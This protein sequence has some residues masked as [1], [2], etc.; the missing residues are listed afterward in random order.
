MLAP[1]AKWINRLFRRKRPAL[2]RWFAG[3]RRGGSADEGDGHRGGQA[4]FREYAKT[5]QSPDTLRRWESA[6]SHRL[7]SGH[8]SGANGDTINNDLAFWLGTLRA[9]CAHE[10]ANNPTLEGVLNTHCTD[11]IGPR[12][13]KLQVQSSKKTYNEKL[14]RIWRD[15]FK[16]PEITGKL[17]GAAMMQLWWRGL[18]G[19][20][21]YLAQIVT[22]KT[23]DGPVKMRLKLVPVRRLATPIAS[24]A[25]ASIVLGVERDANGKPVAYHIAPAADSLGGWTGKS[26]RIEAKHII[27]EFCT[28]EEEQV[29]GVPWLAV[30]LK[31]IADTRDYDDQVLDAAR[32]AA[33]YSVMMEATGPDVEF[34]AVN[35]EIDI[36]PGVIRH[37]VPGWKANGLTPPQPSTQYKDYHDEL[38]RNFGRAV[39]MPLMMIKLDSAKHNY[40]SARF[41]AQV[42][43]RANDVKKAWIADG[44]M[45]R[46][47]DLVAREAE[48]TGLLPKRPPHV[49]YKWTWHA[50]ASVD[51]IKD[52][53]AEQQRLANGTTTLRDEC[54][55]RGFDWEEVI[56]QRAREMEALQTAGLAAADGKKQSKEIEA[57]AKA[58]RIG[59]PI[60]VNEARTVLGL[61]IDPK[62]GDDRLRFNDQ[63]V[64][65]Y[66][67]ES[68]VLTI[69]EARK[70]LG[71]P[72][73]EWGNVPV[74]KQGLAAVAPDAPAGEKE[75]ETE[76]ETETEGETDGE[77]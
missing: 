52:A 10:I 51:P 9:R 32:I 70:R 55:A 27:H 62:A 66:H 2:T 13:P 30:A 74:R 71:L 73:A 53:K 46:L 19:N 5:S 22:D 50:A 12:G 15:W 8:W 39:C 54:A 42:Y 48:L 60:K 68:G 31:N 59:V 16:R 29:D 72:D 43:N 25:D 65:Q 69:N 57:I 28:L 26:R 33:A 1:L 41:D 14:E 61:A 36:E 49:E 17:T 3:A 47:V 6:A 24:V 56:V 21:A 76:S 40:S 75:S 35:E 34:Q 20:G 44:V 58:V 23:A 45:E 4:P 37:A 7:N 38:L 11:V 64:L 67:I 77:S 63:D 18:W